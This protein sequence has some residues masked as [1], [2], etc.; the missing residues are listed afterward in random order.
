MLRTAIAPTLSNQIRRDLFSPRPVADA[1]PTGNPLSLN[2]L[3]RNPVTGGVPM[4]LFVPKSTQ[5]GAVFC[6]A[7]YPLP[8]LSS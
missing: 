2:A 8:S 4:L 6:V 3:Q 1:S 5:G 7:R